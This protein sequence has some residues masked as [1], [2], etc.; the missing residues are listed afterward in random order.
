MR[1]KHRID[2]VL[3]VLFGRRR[4]VTKNTATI[5]ESSSAR[6]RRGEDSDA[7]GG[8][9]RRAYLDVAYINLVIVGGPLVDFRYLQNGI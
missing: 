2:S 1:A 6:G 9:A 3:L 8:D 7:G 5:G 4:R